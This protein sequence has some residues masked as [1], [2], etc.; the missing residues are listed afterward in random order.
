MQFHKC[1]FMFMHEKRESVTKKILYHADIPPLS[2]VNS[3][4]ATPCAV[5][6]R[7]IQGLSLARFLDGPPSLAPSLYGPL[8]A[9]RYRIQKMDQ[10]LSN[11]ILSYL[12]PFLLCK[13]F[14]AFLSQDKT[15]KQFIFTNL[16]SKCCT[17]FGTMNTTSG[18]TVADIGS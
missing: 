18:H 1:M 13:S 15:S 3:P 6:D 12:G 2:P 14:W 11:L 7:I 5:W 17:I 16:S 10:R 8:T 4:P 9:H